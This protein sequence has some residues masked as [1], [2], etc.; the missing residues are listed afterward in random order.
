MVAGPIVNQYH[1]LVTRREQSFCAN[2][3]GL[4]DGA[5][6]IP[7]PHP[8]WFLLPSHYVQCIIVLVPPVWIKSRRLLSE[9]PLGTI[10]VPRRSLLHVLHDE[11]T[12]AF[13][14][15]SC[16]HRA[17]YDMFPPGSRPADVYP[18]ALCCRGDAVPHS[19]FTL[20]KSRFLIRTP[21]IIGQI[22]PVT[23]VSYRVEQSKSRIVQLCLRNEVR[24]QCRSTPSARATA[25]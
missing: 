16:D 17:R 12:Q 25:S 14:G 19:P 11:H 4:D 6:V 9:R 13:S 7:L 5:R 2:G 1:A 10:W 3:C 22:S 8:Y 21:Q 18:A 24:M 15:D 23:R 20:L